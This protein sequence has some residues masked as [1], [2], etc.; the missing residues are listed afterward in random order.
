MGLEAAGLKSNAGNAFRDSRSGL[1]RGWERVES[2]GCSY[3][4][5]LRELDPSSAPGRTG[6]MKGGFGA[7]TDDSLFLKLSTS[8]IVQDVGK[9]SAIVSA[10]D[11]N[12]RHNGFTS[13]SKGVL[14]N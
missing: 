4:D 8:A 12:A 5:V 9:T 7:G 6:K 13:I 11:Q 3:D 2:V 14:G 10:I 1:G